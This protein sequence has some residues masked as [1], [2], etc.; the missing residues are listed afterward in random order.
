MTFMI[1]LR[2]K[3][4]PHATFISFIVHLW[5]AH[6][7]LPRHYITHTRQPMTEIYLPDLIPLQR[8][9]FILLVSQI[10]RCIPHTRT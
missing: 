6:K 3:S 2:P 8:N 7:N 10:K 4:F 5:H 9:H 1:M